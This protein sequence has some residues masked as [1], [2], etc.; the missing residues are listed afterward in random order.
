MDIIFNSPLVDYILLR[1]VQDNKDDVMTFN[2]NGTI[3][4]FSKEEFLLVSDC[5]DHVIQ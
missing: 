2:L 4:M 5:G 1:E 3:I